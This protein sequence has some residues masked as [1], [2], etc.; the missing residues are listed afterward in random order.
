MNNINAATL[1]LAFILLGTGTGTGARAEGDAASKIVVTP[2]LSADVNSAGQPIV[3][4]RV[5]GH[6]TVSLFE[7]PPDA[8][9]P[10]H[11]HPF[12]RMGYVLSGSLRVTNLQTGVSQT[13]KA[14]DAVL[15]SVGE[16]HEGTNPGRDMLRLLVIDLL[17]S[18]AENTVLR[19]TPPK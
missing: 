2:V 6:V 16:W 8:T 14:G 9:L 10:V 1:G 5:N 3:F 11:K 19:D 15:E 4:P 17:E 13:Y 18:G 7:I 12:P